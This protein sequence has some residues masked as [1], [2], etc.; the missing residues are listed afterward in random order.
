MIRA[1]NTLIAAGLA[2][3]IVFAA[4][5]EVG[6]VNTAARTSLASFINNVVSGAVN[7]TINP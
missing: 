1:R 5:C 3:V 7:A 6:I 2:M 4:G